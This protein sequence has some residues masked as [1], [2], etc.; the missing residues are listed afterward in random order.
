MAVP[1]VLANHEEW[2]RVFL[3]T[4]VYKLPRISCEPSLSFSMRTEQCTLECKAHLH[5]KSVLP[6]RNSD[7]G[8]VALCDGTGFLTAYL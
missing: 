8:P 5:A 4:P 6:T 1:A 7:A 2:S 3:Q